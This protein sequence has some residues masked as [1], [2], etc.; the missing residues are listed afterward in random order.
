MN[1]K[2]GCI[3]ARREQMRVLVAED[4][5]VSRTV[6]TENLT[7]W[8]YDVKTAEDGA[9]AWQVLKGHE[10]PKMAILDWMMPKM[11]G[12]EV[13]RRVRQQ[14]G[15][16]S[17][18]IL[19]LTAK[20][21]TRDVVDA[22]EAGADDYLHKP[23]SA[24]ELRARVSV[25]LRFISIRAQ[26]A[27][28][29]QKAEADY[30]SIFENATEGIFQTT[31]EG[32]YL[33]ANPAL[34]EIYGYPSP[35]V[36]MNAITDLKTQ[37]YLDPRRRDE[38]K[39]LIDRDRRVSAFESEIRRPD[40]TTAWISENTRAVCNDAGETLYYEGT[41]TDVT[42]RKAAEREVEK[43]QLH[44]EELVEKRTEEFNR[45]N[46]Q[47]QKAMKEVETANRAKSEFLA[48][49]SHE[50]RTPM[51]AIIGF[52]EVLEKKMFGDL[53]P[54]QEKYTKN[55][56]ASG[57]HLLSLIN[58]ILDISKVEAG[59]MDL[60]L[61]PVDIKELLERSLIIIKET[62]INN[63]ISV[64]LRVSDLLADRKIVVDERKLK[65]VVFNLL[66]NA[67]K[68]THTGGNVR[69]SARIDDCRLRRKDL[70][71]RPDSHRFLKADDRA[72]H[73]NLQ[74]VEV[75]V[76]DSGIGIAPEDLER[77]FME[78]EQLESS[79]GH[80]FEGTGLGLSLAERLVAL[81]GGRIWVESEGEGRGS[82]FFFRIPAVERP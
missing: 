15:D 64:D 61:S 21:E 2:Q 29:A 39:R 70:E 59:K 77:V 75:C 43:Y 34:A 13:C 36:L 44:L 31:L 69:I 25:G 74:C 18:Y 62:A 47:L 55:I 72:S 58:D 16:R 33:I 60:D 66:S 73:V 22:F 8:G 11:T 26:M 20:S 37:L 46:Q 32:S 80:K 35:R 57:R 79:A 56:L 12:V 7:N 1:R 50:L 27:R 51:N 38:F 41:V 19:M 24:A 42:Q 4:D 5:P 54:R 30:R 3:R 14:I 10:P 65:Q 67:A 76:A 68:F 78:F 17:S 45:A 48:N 53:T 71:R 82:N 49:M 52:S 81:H 23:F 9:D 28:R 6:L 40:G 63:G